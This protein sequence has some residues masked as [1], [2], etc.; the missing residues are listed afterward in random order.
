M[1]LHLTRADSSIEFPRLFSENGAFLML[2]DWLE[3]RDFALKQGAHDGV[4]RNP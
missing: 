3:N 2:N 4:Q 1:I